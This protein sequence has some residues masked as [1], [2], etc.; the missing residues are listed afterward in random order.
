M[1]I[2]PPRVAII[3][4]GLSGV[5]SAK[6]LK[7][8]GAEIVVYERSS[9]SGGNWV[10]DERRAPEPIYPSLNPSQADL[11]SMNSRATSNGE[12]EQSFLNDDHENSLKFDEIGLAYAPPGPAYDGLTTNVSTNLQ[13]LK[14]YPWPEGNEQFVNVRVCGEY[15]QSYSREFGIE[16]VTK[17]DTRVEN[18]EK[19]GGKWNVES[20]TL[21]HEGPNKGV[22]TSDSD[23]GTSLF[24]FDRVVV[25]NGH[26]HASKVPDTPG[27]K[28]WKYT[29]PDKVQHSKSY[30]TPDGFKDQNVLLIGAGVSST[31]IA[32][33]LSQVAKKIYQSSRGG[34]YDLPIELLPPIASRVAEVAHFEIPTKDQTKPG[35][36]TLKD[37][38]VLTD[39][40]R[41]IVCTGYHFSLPFLRS[42]HSDSTA[43][44]KAN[45]TVLVTD[46]TQMHNL[47]KD[48][49][50]IPDP[51]LAFVGVPFYTATF[52]FFEFQAI[53][54]AAVFS[55]RA[56]LP[57]EAEMRTEYQERVQRK[58]S[59][60][61]FH[62]MKGEEAGYVKG[63]VDWVNSHAQLTDGP[64]VV[65]HSEEWLAQREVLRETFLKFLAA[66]ESRERE[67]NL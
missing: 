59:G 38:Q 26:Y 18:I 19:R 40:D 56:W 9:K 67:K 2:K 58:G 20:S 28:E 7:Y 14:D 61:A 63:L 24:E 6:H 44:D 42:F 31:D 30:R 57:T 35:G 12:Q 65:G 45:D 49:F 62:D 23:V 1:A 15:I 27:L 51:T 64:K 34:P 21:I 25:A 32:R 17:Y 52:S 47:H 54:V 13:E 5:V 53:A 60:R 22:I 43:A 37:G 66:K 10:Y 46:G 3:G 16:Q 8:S 55:G 41:V 4:A 50:Y 48:L 36:V 29:W 39:I 11:A 33:E